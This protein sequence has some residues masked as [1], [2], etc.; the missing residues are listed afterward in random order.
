MPSSITA[1]ALGGTLQEIVHWQ[2]VSSGLLFPLPELCLLLS[3]LSA[4]LSAIFAL[5]LCLAVPWV[6]VK[7][8][9][10]AS[11]KYLYDGMAAG[12]GRS[13]L[14]VPINRLRPSISLSNF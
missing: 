6:S 5:N 2:R 9:P 14:K 3:S 10:V 8:F 1:D 11:Y 12:I 7:L 13:Q 4:F